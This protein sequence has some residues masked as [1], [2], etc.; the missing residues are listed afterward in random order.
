MLFKRGPKSLRGLLTD[1][2]E[3]AVDGTPTTSAV[4]GAEE[5]AQVAMSRLE[6]R[7]Q[8]TE[9]LTLGPCRFDLCS[10]PRDA[11][12]TAEGVGLISGETRTQAGRCAVLR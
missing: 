6:K 12:T 7:L 8:R 10:A 2:I 3:K 11:W 1:S 5:S 9:R 4:V